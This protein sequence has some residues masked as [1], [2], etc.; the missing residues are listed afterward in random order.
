VDPREILLRLFQNEA[1]FVI[2]DPTEM[3]RRQAKKTDYVGT[4]SDG[5]TPGYWV[6]FLA[7]PFHGRAI[8]CGF[9]SYSSK[10]IAA[11][12]SSRNRHH[13][14]A[15]AKI[16]ELL[17]EKPLVLDREFSYLEL[18]E[19]LLFE[20]VNFVIHL[21]TG[22][23]FYDQERKQVALSISKGETRTLNKVFYKGKVFVN[24]IGIWRPGFSAPLWIMTNLDAQEA[25]GIYLQRMKIEEAFRD[26]KSLLGLEKLM[27]K[28]RDQMEKTIAMLL[29]AYAISLW[30]GET[31]RAK[32][33]P[34]GT[35]KHQL[36]S[37]LFVFLKLKPALS[38]PEYSR[39]SLHALASFSSLITSCPN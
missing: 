3:P 8:P 36:F 32:L 39:L 28:Q 6:L 31:L 35:R 9:V 14:E 25:L 34:E 11:E 21:N 13:F 27:N 12:A 19:N 26:M 17:G 38:P 7:T 5:E 30:L 20:E 37:G 15:F 23:N 29:I 4:L 16:K 33:F 10:T 22:V 1:P 24:V 18:L 2:G